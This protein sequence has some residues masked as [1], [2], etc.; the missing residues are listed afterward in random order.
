MIGDLE[1]RMGR[2]SIERNRVH[3]YINDSIGHYDASMC[4]KTLKSRHERLRDSAMLKF[5]GFGNSREKYLSIA[6]PI[7]KEQMLMTRASIRANFRSTQFW[8][9]TPESVESKVQARNVE[10]LITQNSR[11]TNWKSVSWQK[12]TEQI[13]KYGATVNYSAPLTKINSQRVPVMHPVFGITYDRVDKEMHTVYNSVIDVRNYGQDPGIACA[14]DSPYQFH[15]EHMHISE[16]KRRVLLAEENE[17]LGGTNPWDKKLLT[18]KLG[19]LKDGYQDAKYYSGQEKHRTDGSGYN[20]HYFDVLH[21]FGILPIE[22]NEDSPHVY[23]AV[24]LEGDIVRFQQLEYYQESPYDIVRTDAHDMYWWGSP[25]GEYRIPHQNFLNIHINATKDSLI[26]SMKEYVFFDKNAG[27]P[28]NLQQIMPWGG[29]VPVDVQNDR[30][31]SDIYNSFRSQPVDIRGSDWIANKV[32]QQMRG[33]SS[34]PELTQAGG[35]RAVAAN[36]ATGVEALQAQGDLMQGDYLEQIAHGTVAIGHTNYELLKHTLPPFF[37]VST[38]ATGSKEM[39]LI[40]IMG[41]M[42]FEVH[43]SLTKNRRSELQRYQ[44]ALTWWMNMAGTGHPA[45]QSTDPTPIYREV[46]RMLDVG[47][48][49]EIVPEE[50]INVD[51][52]G[53]P[54]QQIQQPAQGAINVAQG[55]GQAGGI[56]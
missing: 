7:V 54:G 31:V 44:N 9:V 23:Y 46:W 16:I 17:K 35:Q 53:V 28:E 19:Q 37:D 34:R 29:M 25:Q 10:M 32:E 22:G 47:D 26:K 49:D 12:H 18:K 6:L 3:D 11:A 36:T 5:P 39:T 13:S 51:G 43:S 55:Q 27:I 42:S 40:D 21:W 38:P 30:R 1:K 2:D 56:V 20:K 50:P 45:F 15:R 14:E 41:A 48:V 8:T 52:M 33:M 4:K 24:L